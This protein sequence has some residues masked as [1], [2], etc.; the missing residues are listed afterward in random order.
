[1]ILSFNIE[2]RTNWGEEVRIS[3]LFPESIPLHTTD[4]IYWTAEVELEIP[5]EGMIINYNY[6]IEQNGIVIR[7]EWDSFPRS[8]FLSGTSKK[9]YRINDC[10]KNIPEQSY[11]YSSAFTEALLAHPERESIPQSYKKGLVIKAY[12]PHINKDYCLAICGNQKS[13]GHWDPEKAVLMSDANFPEWQIELDASKL[14]YPLEYK[15]ILYNKQ[16]KKADCWEKNPNR[17]LAD[18]ELKTNETLVISDRYAYFDI[19]AWKGAGIAIPVFSLKSEKSF[20]VGDFG[21]LK[22]MIDWAVS[23]H[24]KVIQILPVNDTTMTH[25]WIDSYPYNSISIYA[26]HPMYA[27]LK[28][29]G[30]LKD[31]ET[32]AAFNRKQKEL[33]ALSA[34]DYEAVNRVKWEYFHQIFKQ[35]GEKVLASK[36]FRSFFEANKDWLQPY[37][38]FSYLRDL[39]HTPNFR[40]WPQYSEYNAQEIEELCRPDTADYAHIAI[41]FYIQFN[42]HLQL[43]EATTYA[44]EHGVVL[45]G[46]IPIGIS[47]NSVEAWTEPYYFNLNGQAGAPPDDFSI[48]G[49]NWGFPTYNWDVMENDGYKWWMKRFQKMAEYFDAYRIDHILGFFRIWEIPMNAV[50]GLLGQF[51]PALPMSREEIESY[52]LSFREEFLRPYIH[53]YF[54]GQVFGPHT[55]YVKQT[56]I[57]P[58]E[59]YEVYRMRPEFDTQ[60]KVEAFFAGKNDEDSIWVRD[61]LYALISDVLFVPDRKDPN[62]Y[63]PRIGVQHDFIYRALNDWE[64]TAFNRLYDQYYYHRH[65]DFWQQQAMKK[66]PQLTQSTRMLVCGEDLGMIPDC[67]AWVMNDLRILSLEIQ[68]MPKNPA[69]EF[70]R[71]NEYPYRSVCTFSTHDMSTL[72][73]WWEEDYQQTQRYYNQMLGHYGAAPAIATPE[74]CEEVVRN[75]LYSNSILCILSLQDWL[76]MD[77]KWRNPNVQEERINIPANPRHYWRYRMHL[78]LEQ[79]MKAESLNEKIRELVKQT[80]RNPEK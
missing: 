73:G 11:L 66:L 29:M 5:H 74:L 68:R 23:T 30:N 32:A 78:T 1:M 47:R 44:R 3:G 46:D 48:N 27:D 38:A 36:A 62:L 7:R 42:L 34:I 59:T 16:E 22:R 33:N 43:L 75:H 26:F 9:I 52:G 37:A 39:Y 70:G 65:N 77:G 54:L 63:H 31:K 79:L 21:D 8:I 51:V 45:K 24:Q 4:G 12:A 14:K 61:G 10:W 40:E 53:E 80:G 64:K 55:D 17:Y 58:T 60:R 28:Q 49:Q 69:E 71:L 13:L 67:V 35:E 2:Y 72:R 57:E 50:H 6:Q 15:F 41:Y 18:P 56:F 19:P 76:S 25:A 20:G